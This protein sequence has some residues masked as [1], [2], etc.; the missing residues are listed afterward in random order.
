MEAANINLIA[1]DNQVSP[2]PFAACNDCETQLRRGCKEV[3]GVGAHNK[4]RYVQAAAKAAR[5][6]SLAGRESGSTLIFAEHSDRLLCDPTNSLRAYGVYQFKYVSTPAES[7]AEVQELI[8]RLMRTAMDAY[9]RSVEVYMNLS[10]EAKTLMILR[11]VPMMVSQV[12]ALPPLLS[13]LKAS[14]MPKKPNPTERTSIY[15]IRRKSGT[16]LPNPPRPVFLSSTANIRRKDLI[17]LQQQ[18]LP[19][20]DGIKL[21][22]AHVLR[23]SKVT[24]NVNCSRR[25][26]GDASTPSLCSISHSDETSEYR[27]ARP[28]T[29]KPSDD[30]TVAVSAIA[31]NAVQSIAELEH[32]QPTGQTDAKSTSHNNRLEEVVQT[33]AQLWPHYSGDE[34]GN[35]MRSWPQK[36]RQVS[37]PRSARESVK[38]DNNCVDQCESHTGEENVEGDSFL[39]GMSTTPRP[40]IHV[41]I[42]IIAS[43]KALGSNPSQSRPHQLAQLIYASLQKYSKVACL[44][45]CVGISDTNVKLVCRDVLFPFQISPAA[46][47]GATSSRARTAGASL[48]RSGSLIHSGVSNTVNATRLLEIE[49]REGKPSRLNVHKGDTTVLQDDIN[50]TTLSSG[51]LPCALL[52]PVGVELIDQAHLFI[53]IPSNFL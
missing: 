44:H 17:S 20:S 10:D 11:H 27:K 25:P 38:M 32:R 19:E 6:M 53:C 1:A 36:K 41:L 2:I 30:D 7:E 18:P 5:Q 4:N 40:T 46:L 9:E 48:R 26:L 47:S 13:K 43:R 49:R 12:V 45:A 34:R 52:P 29:G 14:V 39:S 28:W 16:A 23:D 31:M 22:S 50:A 37:I 3:N 42:D 24:G 35:L 8:D 15:S 51:L 21:S 33:L